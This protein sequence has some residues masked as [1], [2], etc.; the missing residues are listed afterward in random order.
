MLVGLQLSPGTPTDPKLRLATTQEEPGSLVV[1]DWEWNPLIL[2]FS[3][4]DSP[5]KALGVPFT[6]NLNWAPAAKKADEI[7]QKA[8]STLLFKRA[9][10][11]TKGAILITCTF[12]AVLYILQFAGVDCSQIARLDKSLLSLYR[13]HHCIGYFT[14]SDILYNPHLGGGLPSLIDHI[15]LRKTNII[16]RLTQEGGRSRSAVSSH[17]TPSR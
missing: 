16:H 14:A 4:A 13:A 3:D 12:N 11:S 2:P 5:V 15:R 6:L 8:C 9:L 7:I 17:A 1:H 10:L